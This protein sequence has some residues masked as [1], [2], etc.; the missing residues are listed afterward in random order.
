[1]CWTILDETA[2]SRN[3]EPSRELK[4]VAANTSLDAS[5]MLK[6]LSN[7]TIILQLNEGDAHAHNLNYSHRL[8]LT[9]QRRIEVP[10][11]KRVAYTR[12]GFAKSRLRLYDERQDLGANKLHSKS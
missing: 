12:R 6:K 8:C 11:H 7:T 9:S 4:N 10:N 5:T 3:R 2:A 1:M